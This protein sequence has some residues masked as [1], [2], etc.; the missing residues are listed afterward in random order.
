VVVPSQPTRIML[1]ERTARRLWIVAVLDMIGVAWMIAA[2]NWFDQTSKLTAVIALGGH[3]E[4]VLILALTGF[5]MLAGLALLTDGFT[6]A[7]RLELAL[8]II[9][10][11]I[12]IAALAGALSAILLVALAA[13]LLGTGLRILLRR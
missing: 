1:S 8:I 2:G 6:S 5:V 9:A 13:L 12:S 3:H 10:C 7:N 4:L 11:V